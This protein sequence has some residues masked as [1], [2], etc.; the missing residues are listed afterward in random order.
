MGS[1]DA[2]HP[3]APARGFE[4]VTYI[5]DGVFRHQDSNGGGLITN[6]DRQC[7]TAGDGIPK[8]VS[9]RYRV[10]ISQVRTARVILAQQRVTER[11]H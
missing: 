1:R 11:R 8:P 6:G 10:W 2:G 5:I 3:V 9:A 4:T 7:M